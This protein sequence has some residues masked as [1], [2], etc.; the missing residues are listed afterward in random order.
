MRKF[1]L[2][3]LLV[4][5]ASTALW[6]QGATDTSHYFRDKEVK[7]WLQTN[8]VSEQD[9]YREALR[10][11][12][13]FIGKYSGYVDELIKNREQLMK[14][15]ETA[16]FKEIKFSKLG[17]SKDFDCSEKRAN[18]FTA[19]TDIALSFMPDSVIDAIN[20]AIKRSYTSGFR[21]YGAFQVGSSWQLIKRGKVGARGRYIFEEACQRTGSCSERGGSIEG[22]IKQA[23]GEHQQMLG[24][25]KNFYETKSYDKKGFFGGSTRYIKKEYSSQDGTWKRYI[26]NHEELLKKELTLINETKQAM[27]QNIRERAVGVLAAIVAH[28]PKSKAL[29]HVREMPQEYQNQISRRVKR[30]YIEGVRD[31]LKQAVNKNLVF[32]PREYTWTQSERDYSTGEYRRYRYRATRYTAVWR[33][34]SNTFGNVDYSGRMYSRDRVVAR[35]CTLPMAT[36][37]VTDEGN[38]VALGF[39]TQLPRESY[40]HKRYVFLNAYNDLASEQTFLNF[41]LDAAYVITYTDYYD[42]WESDLV[43]DSG[44]SSSWGTDYSGYDGWQENSWNDSGYN[45]GGNSHSTY[46]PPSGGSW[47]NDSYNNSG[48]TGNTWN[49][50]NY[51]GHSQPGG[52]YQDNGSGSWNDS[53]SDSYLNDSQ[54][55]GSNDPS[56]GWNDLGGGG[57]NTW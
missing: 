30:A 37:R 12:Q 27:T 43:Y 22:D 50:D 11:A 29:D 57:G 40:A 53:P 24:Q 39:T 14:L 25:A 23:F 18:R 34:Y 44:W 41:L 1:V 49:D 7:E 8:R 26:K 28:F 15:P 46:T 9:A 42:R 47:N 54:P 48:S 51:G 4:C 36:V 6:A 5:F 2:G 32:I 38:R 56:S 13:L 17:F 21:R 3:A 33:P 55:S 16:K 20:D 35:F 45:S 52:T 19:D 10:R 31:G